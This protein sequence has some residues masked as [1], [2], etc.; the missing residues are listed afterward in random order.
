MYLV[1]TF[2]MAN[3]PH[4]L[5]ENEYYHIYNR[6]NSKQ[7]IFLDQQD[8]LLFQ[9]LL[10]LMNM[11]KRITS[12]EIGEA[13]YSYP[14][15]E[16]LVSIGA[17]CLMPNHF[18]ILVKQNLRKVFQSLCKK[19]R[20]RMLCISIRNIKELEASLRELSRQSM[21]RVMIT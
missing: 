3:R 4:S 12:R 18:H 19:F 1:Y 17:Y 16:P 11:E 20:R 14:R 8:Y 13:T 21:L 6:G 7:V 5:L 10:Y 2:C 15:G 9:H